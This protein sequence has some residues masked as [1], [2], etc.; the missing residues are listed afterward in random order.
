MGTINLTKL[1]AWLKAWW[2][3]ILPGVG[4]LWTAYGHQILGYIA[5]HPQIA[6]IVATL[7][8]IFAHLM[9]SPVLNSNKLSVMR[10]KD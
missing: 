7:Y 5:A 10:A 2:P 8:A 6:G 3:T 1:L 9:P 4:A